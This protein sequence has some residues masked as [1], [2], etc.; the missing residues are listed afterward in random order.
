[1]TSL[2]FKAL[3]KKERAKLQQQEQQE[4][5]DQNKGAIGGIPLHS[6]SLALASRSRLDLSKFKVAGAVDGI[7]YVPG[8]LSEEDA[9]HLL[10]AIDQVSFVVMLLWKGWDVCLCVC[11]VVYIL[12]ISGQSNSRCF[13]PLSRPPYPSRT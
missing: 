1:M 12:A 13:S 4:N 3:L 5:Q 8:W 2:D 9:Q 7:H 11:V 10:K 6:P